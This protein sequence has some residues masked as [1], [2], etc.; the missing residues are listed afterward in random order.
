VNPDVEFIKKKVKI[1]K[2]VS[3]LKF[4]AMKTWW[5]SGG[6]VPIILKLGTRWRRVVRFKPW[7]LLL[8]R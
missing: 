8:P 1:D 2:V 5:G 4:H 7:P 6:I 3:A